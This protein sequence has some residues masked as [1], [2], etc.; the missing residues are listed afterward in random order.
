MSEKDW[1]E[2]VAEAER[3]VD[4]SFSSSRKIADGIL[5]ARDLIAELQQAQQWISV[6]TEPEKNGLYLAVNK[7]GD[8]YVEEYETGYGWHDEYYDYAIA[9]WRPLPPA[10]EVKE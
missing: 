5:Y 3:L 8:T 1:T 9:Y 7:F 2:I 10:P 6:E 4:S